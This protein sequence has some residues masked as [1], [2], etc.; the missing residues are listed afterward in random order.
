MP[1]KRIPQ[2]DAIAGAS[3]ANDDN[4]VIYDTDAGTTKRILRSQLAAGLVGDLPYTPSG[5]IA[6]TTVPT[7]IAELDSEAA[8]SAALA[9]QGGAALIGNT[10]AG[11]IAATTVQGAINEIV[12]DLAASSGSSLVGYTQGGISAVSRT[13]QGKLRES[14]SV[15]DFGAVGNGV[16]DDTAAFSGFVAE[17]QVLV[18]TGELIGGETYLLDT[19]STISPSQPLNIDGNFAT[20]KGPTS[21]VDLFKPDVEINLHQATVERWG[22]AIQRL[23]ADGGSITAARLDQNTFSDIAGSV[24]NVE[25]PFSNYWLHGNTITNTD[26]GYALRIGRNTYAEQDNWKNGSVCF[27][28]FSDID[29]ASSSSTSPG[30]IYGKDTHVAFNRMDGVQ[31]ASGEAWGFYTKL[32]YGNIVFNDVSSVNS[33]SSSDVT[34]ITV[35]GEVRA[36]STAPQGFGLLALGNIIRDIG[37]SGTK[38]TGVRVQ[39]DEAYAA[40]NYVSDS[41]FSGITIDEPAANMCGAFFNRVRYTTATGTFG[42]RSS[43]GGT[44]IRYIGNEIFNAATGHRQSA[45]GVGN[46][47]NAVVIAQNHY[48]VTGIAI[49]V[50]A[51]S[52]TINGLTVQNNTV[53]AGTD[54]LRFD[55]GTLTN[56]RVLDND[57]RSATT[58][59]AGTMPADVQVRHCWTFATANSTTATALSFTI[60][61]ESAYGIE[62]R[63][64]AK[65]DDSSERA[66]YKVAAL[67]YRDGGGAT[68]Q[69]TVQSLMTPIESAGATGW[70]C[71]VDVSGNT[72]RVRVTGAASNTVN[73]KL[74]ANIIGA[75]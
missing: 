48:N 28:I 25:T 21:R 11:T 46:N 75:M 19:W 4:L 64:T 17:Q 58:Q 12:S 9:A 49:Q 29:G 62:V 61:D 2:L 36:A 57:F 35:K 5:G 47:A 59:I 13:V 44:G 50:N 1:G 71:T 16:T 45:G 66:M 55:G 34:G 65:Q 31:A 22:S 67:V 3:T 39:A 42:I 41:G 52:Q 51:T 72:V 7:A 24:V 53:S 8:K 37:V 20:V 70:D 63:A 69:G 23:I 6:A 43:Q 74:E 26:G 68:L 56:V 18:N 15:K 10:P 14:V 38:G 27:N 33:T 60:A 73:W 40:F 32:R 30:I 54:G